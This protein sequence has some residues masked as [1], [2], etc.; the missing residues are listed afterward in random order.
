MLNFQSINGDIAINGKV[1]Q[2][3]RAH[4]IQLQFNP[5]EERVIKSQEPKI[6]GVNSTKKTAFVSKLSIFAFTQKKS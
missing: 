5:E 3:Q 2:Q 4:I 6:A 1:R